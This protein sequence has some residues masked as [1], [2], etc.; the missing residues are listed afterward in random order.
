MFRLPVTFVVL[1]L[2][3]AA[4]AFVEKFGEDHPRRG[5][6]RLARSRAGPGR[7]AGAGRGPEGVNPGPEAL[8]A[9]PETDAGEHPREALRKGDRQIGWGGRRPTGGGALIGPP[10]P[11]FWTTPHSP[12]TVR[13]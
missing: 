13:H 1:L 6:T 10:P 7:D 3:P 11:H 8:L 4:L 12:R 2:A 5:V 9:R